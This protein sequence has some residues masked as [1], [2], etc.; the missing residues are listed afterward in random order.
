MKER[1]SLKV[2]ERE[3]AVVPEGLKKISLWIMHGR[4]LLEE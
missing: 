3:L 1:Y 4:M 2:K